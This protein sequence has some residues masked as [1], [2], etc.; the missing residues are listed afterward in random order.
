MLLFADVGID[1]AVALI[2][3]LLH[4]RIRVL[5]VVASFGNTPRKLLLIVP[6]QS[7]NLLHR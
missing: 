6:W 7:C 3:A 5:G 1:D 4:P 2:Y